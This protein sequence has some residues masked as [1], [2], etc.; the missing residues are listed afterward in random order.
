MGPESVWEAID[1]LKAD[2]VLHG[3]TAVT[4][5][6]LVA[7]LVEREICLDI[8]PTSNQL[9]DVVEDLS[10][11]PI[12]VLLEAGV[13]CSINADD[14]ILFGPNIL[15]EYELAR[16][17]IGLTDEQLAACALSSI[18][19]TLAPGAVKTKARTDIDAWLASSPA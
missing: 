17:T 8:C 4:D 18:E 3:V 11:H 9:L 13:R 15:Q 19:C 16:H 1:V 10:Q 2:R 14:P 6:Q 12:K 7:Q 5:E